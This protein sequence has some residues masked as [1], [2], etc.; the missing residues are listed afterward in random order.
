MAISDK[1]HSALLISMDGLTPCSEII[2]AIL[3]PSDGRPKRVLDI[4]M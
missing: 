1:Q 4:G 2:D 3:T